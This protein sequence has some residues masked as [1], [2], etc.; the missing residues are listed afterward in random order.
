MG[1][2]ARKAAL[3]EV[4]SRS[5]DGNC[6][7]RVKG[8]QPRINHA[9]QTPGSTYL[10]GLLCLPLGHGASTKLTKTSSLLIPILKMRFCRECEKAEVDDDEVL[11][12][13]VM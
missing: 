13:H 4:A 12:C 6:G 5:S 10:Q 7:N 2:Y 8:Q 9:G 11:Q 3:C 1:S